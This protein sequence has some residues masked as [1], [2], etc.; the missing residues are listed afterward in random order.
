M[1]TMDA[2]ADVPVAAGATVAFA[3][4][5]RHAMLFDLAAGVD[6]QIKLN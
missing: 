2:M 3:P 5:G 4:G 1:M 6:V